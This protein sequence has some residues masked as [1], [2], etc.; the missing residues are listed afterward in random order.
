M[1]ALLASVPAAY[2]WPAQFCIATTAVTWILS[3]L[4]ANV[5]QVD[6]LWTF[7]PTI[8]TAYYALM[9]LWPQEPLFPLCPYTPKDLGWAVAKDFSPRALLMFGIV[10]VWMCRLSYNTYRRGLFK[11]QDEDYR[12]AVLRAKLPAWLFQL[13]NLTFIAATQNVLLLLLGMPTKI[14]STMQPHD[15][16]ALSDL[17]LAALALVDLAFE[18]TS[19]N[20]QWAYHSYKHAYLASEK[21]E[22]GVEPYDKKQQWPGA[23]LN[24]TPEDAKRGFI[25]RGLWA[26]SRHPN[27]LCEQSFWWIITFFPLLAPA[28]PHLSFTSSPFHLIPS[29]TVIRQNPY[30]LIPIL[31]RLLAPLANLIPALSLSALFFSS[32]IFTE[33]ISLSKYPKEYRAYQKRVGMFSP[34]RTWEKG[35]VLAWQGKRKAVEEVVWGTGSKAGKKE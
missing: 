21:G 6:R 22:N 24:F 26:Y 20:Q 35:L 1:D 23:R 4:T 13:T 27:F 8:Y 16:L 10:F 19:D 30:V 9:P 2:Q 32:T 31:E 3:L 25:T 34:L 14:A 15:S 33:S 18:F 11:L 29:I 12:W 17:L 28:P 5:S 7:L